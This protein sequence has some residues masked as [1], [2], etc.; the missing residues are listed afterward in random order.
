MAVMSKY[1][2]EMLEQKRKDQELSKRKR[3]VGY[4][5]GL[6]SIAFIVVF[7]WFL[8]KDKVHE[9]WNTVDKELTSETPKSK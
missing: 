7:L 2:L 6:A 3:V 1:E 8:L 9:S 5:V 4:I